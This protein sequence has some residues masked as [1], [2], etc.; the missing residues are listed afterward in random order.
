[1]GHAQRQLEVAF[2]GKKNIYSNNL[3]IIIKIQKKK[4]NF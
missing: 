4:S 2:H 3:N 1:M